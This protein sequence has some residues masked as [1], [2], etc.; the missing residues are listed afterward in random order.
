VRRETEE[1]E[2]SEERRGSSVPGRF[3]PALHLCL[4][5]GSNGLARAPLEG[6]PRPRTVSPRFGSGLSGTLRGRLLDAGKS[7]FRGESAGMLS[8]P[9]S[10]RLLVPR[11]SLIAAP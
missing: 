2:E 5:Q 4:F 6:E 8:A 7:V 11:I 3:L 9:S 10:W 1:M